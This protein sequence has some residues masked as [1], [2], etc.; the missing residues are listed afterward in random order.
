MTINWQELKKGFSEELDKS[1]NAAQSPA[2]PIPPQPGI[3]DNLRTGA[4]SAWNVVSNTRIPTPLGPMSI[5][6]NPIAHGVGAYNKVQNVVGAVGDMG[7]AVVKGAPLLLGG[8][9]AMG[10][11][12][13]MGKKQAPQV[14]QQAFPG[15]RKS[16]LSY[17]TMGVNT[18]FKPGPIAY[19]GNGQYKM[20]SENT[21]AANQAI[22]SLLWAARNRVANHV[23]N[24]ITQTDP[25]HGSVGV[26]KPQ[27]SVEAQTQDPEA[28]ALTSEYPEINEML[29]NDETRAYLEKLLKKSV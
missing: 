26:V 9:L 21:K 22:D 16:V 24:E 20:G 7:S 17:D 13:A 10:A 25:S 3:I 4:Q 29:K 18:Q 1:A 15:Q 6:S 28:I 19:N 12:G 14:P 2:Q 27:G 11:A 8:I 5:N 23:L